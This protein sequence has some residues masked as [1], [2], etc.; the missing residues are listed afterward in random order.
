[1][2]ALAATA[3]TALLTAAL[4][5]AA[6]PA[7]AV[8]RSAH[9]VQ[10]HVKKYPTLTALGTV[11]TGEVY[12]QAVTLHATV[13]NTN[14]AFTT[15]NQVEFLDGATVIGLP[16]AVVPGTGTNPYTATAQITSSTIP[17][18]TNVISAQF[19]TSTNLSSSKS[20]AQNLVIAKASTTTSITST[21]PASSVVYGQSTTFN[22]SVAAVAPGSGTPTGTVA[23]T[24]GATAICTATLSGSTGTGSCAG[25][26]IATPAS[27]VPF[28]A[29]YSG[30]PN[31]S[32]SSDAT[33]LAVGQS[34]TT[35]STFTVAP[36]S[37]GFGGET[38]VVFS[39][40]VTA[41]A[42]G[43]GTPTGLVAVTQ[44]ST[45]LCTM[46]L[47]AGAGSCSPSSGTV[48]SVAAYAVTATYSGSA[49]YT[50]SSK[51]GALSV[52][53]ATTSLGSI[54]VSPAP[55]YGGPITANATLTI[56]AG[57]ASAAGTVTFTIASG[58]N[59]Y[60][61]AK[62]TSA[63]G[64]LSCAS[65]S[66][67]AASAAVPPAGTYSVSAS[68]APTDSTDIA[69]AG[70]SSGPSFAIG[71]DTT[72]VAVV[73]SGTGA[74]YAAE[75]DATFTVTVSTGFGETLPATES[76]TVHVGAASCLASI[77]PTSGGASGSCSIANTALPVGGPYS[78][79]VSYAGDV[80]LSGSGPSPATTTFTVGP[81][82]ATL[83]VSA[84]PG[85][86]AYGAE[87][88]AVFSVTLTTTNG[89]SLPG[90]EGVTVTVG[91]S[92]CPVTLAPSGGGGHGSCSLA[93]SVALIAGGP[94]AVS[95]TYPGDTDISPAG[96][97]NADGGLTVTKD[98]AT[99][100]VSATP[101]TVT[102]GHE[103]ASTLAVSLTTGNGEVMPGSESV[104]IDVGA[105]ASCLATVNPGGSGGAGSCTISDTA[106]AAGG[107]YDVSA[108]YTGDA[109]IASSGPT[110]AATGLTVNQDSAALVVGESATSVVFGNESTI[111]FSATLSTGNGESLPAAEPLTINVG[112]ASCVATLSP[113]GAGAAGSC[114]I[115]DAD[116]TGGGP[117]TISATYP[118]DADLTA[119][120]LASA[121]SGLTVTTDSTLA[122]PRVSEVPPANT[123]GAENQTI[124]NVTV[125]TGNGEP[126]PDGTDTATVYV[127]PQSCQTVLAPSG[128][129][130]TGSCTI[131]ATQ[132]AA[133]ASYPVS[134]YY[135]GD[136]SLQPDGPIDTATPFTVSADTTQI[137]V[138]ASPTTVTYG[139]ESASVFSVNLTTG[140]GESMPA[141]EPVTVD[142]GT[143]S[144]I[145]L[146]APSSG[147]G[148]GTCSIADSDLTTGTNYPVSV[149]Y[150]GDVDL[151]AS[152]PSGALV[153]L[154][155][156]KIDTTTA[157]NSTV[158]ADSIVYGQSTT[159]HVTVGAVESTSLAPT[160]SVSI[161][162]GASTICTVNLV[163]ANGGVGSCAGATLVDPGSALVFHASYAGDDNFAASASTASRTVVT[164]TSAVA[165]SATRNPTVTGGATTLHAA[166]SVLAPGS[167]TPVGTVRFSAKGVTIPGCAAVPVAAGTAACAGASG[168]APGSYPLVA[169]YSGDA[170]V[171][172]SASPTLGLLVDTKNTA[173][174]RSMFE[175]LLG[176]PADARSLVVD[177]ALLKSG[178][179]RS[180]VA[181]AI[182]SSHEYKID[183]VRAMISAYLGRSA[184]GPELVALVTR[185]DR[186]ATYEQVRASILG[187][188]EFWNK[189]G[190]TTGGFVQRLYLDVLG[191]S[192]SPAAS[193]AIAR[194]LAHHVTRTG[195]ALGLL[196]STEARTRLVHGWISSIL[197]RTNYSG[198]PSF[199]ALLGLGVRDETIVDAMVGSTEYFNK[200]TR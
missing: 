169:T 113:G 90:S 34:A 92:S 136:A 23:V 64:A 139:H 192:A 138:A 54:A 36:G 179:S 30:A 142:A 182:T 80:D 110:S 188:T 123:Y 77:S 48:L 50:G 130:G 189:A 84:S 40:S 147:G 37:V 166:V 164:A 180:Q 193:A 66:P 60:T 57:S 41:S 94:Y 102:Y 69:P 197:M 109:D 2:H 162:E 9:A 170:D 168:L 120:S 31:F 185:L 78:I 15:S 173:F 112:G 24:Q 10:P 140:N 106:V 63:A 70:P 12:G 74:T 148:A 20:V 194:A 65:W 135:S 104:S 42:P 187:G 195:V 176:R 49:D 97:S 72:H 121:P 153:G 73:A 82:S 81:D 190:H 18:G 43:S 91:S 39:A 85:T 181:A 174:I 127:G 119:S 200:V 86:V 161:T 184:T 51:D 163:S 183:Q 145:A 149:T 52:T 79:T 103:S 22:V 116:L 186:G 95:S 115:G 14:H 111:T 21:S 11:P 1:M 13:T 59:S 96:P 45:A 17:A 175:T 125:T 199:V 160:G 143:S 33:S 105:G 29:A 132:L 129:G 133:G 8:V 83:T 55:S 144:C 172:G 157:V 101:S 159:F 4:P 38:S 151:L 171:A 178:H 46:T 27:S 6:S 165:L 3:V 98:T 128:M 196:S 25:P 99:L 35:V 126:L 141:S 56:A 191:H 61:C 134:V 118:G 5:I 89:E 155:V 28:T 16:V 158:P 167:G 100:H 53:R 93:S 150:P 32:T 107:P 124:F 137:A 117:Y 108:T 122:F 71:K 76:A 156:A 198:T 26:A 47:S 75:S 62:A 87:G 68:F 58:P 146:L 88:A 44:G 19:M 7:G 152:G 114:S 67:V 177:N 131:G 154:S